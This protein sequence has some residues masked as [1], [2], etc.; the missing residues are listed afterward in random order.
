[1]SDEGTGDAA[2]EAEQAG[3]QKSESA[4]ESDKKSTEHGRSFL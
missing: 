2:D 1:M 3:D 4:A